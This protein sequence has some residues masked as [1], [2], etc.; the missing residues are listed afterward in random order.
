MINKAIFIVSLNSKRLNDAIN[1]KSNF[2]FIHDVEDLDVF[3][4]DTLEVLNG[5][6]FNKT[7]AENQKSEIEKIIKR[8]E[9][10]FVGFD[11][12][13]RQLLRCSKMRKLLNP[14]IKAVYDEL[15]S[16]SVFESHC[17][18]QIFQNLQPKLRKQGVSNNRSDLIELLLPFL[19]VELA[20][21]LYVFNVETY[22]QI[23]GME[24]EMN[25]IKAIKNNK[26]ESLN[27][28]VSRPVEYVKI[29]AN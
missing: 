19:L 5:I 8:L 24:T 15:F 3:V 11:K 2:H 21:Y 18:N 28:F 4:F 10:D 17:R 16:N 13:K 7:D 6:F 23:Y 1:N 9:N 25:I 29:T 12:R 22:D 26:Y 20:L 14:Y 27:K